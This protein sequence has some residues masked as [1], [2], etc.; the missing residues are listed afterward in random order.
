MVAAARRSIAFALTR[1]IADN[2]I[3]HI[4]FSG[5]VTFRN[6]EELREVVKMVPLDR[7]FG[8]FHDGTPEAHEAMKARRQRRTA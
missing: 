7:W 5:I 4:S 6:A 1:V 8:S 3:I 2:R